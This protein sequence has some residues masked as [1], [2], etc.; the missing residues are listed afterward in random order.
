[1]N[2]SGMSQARMMR[3]SGR[4]PWYERLREHLIHGLDQHNPKFLAHF[5]RQIANV[6]FVQLGDDDGFDPRPQG[7]N[8]LLLQ[9]TDREDG[10]RR[11]TSP[12]MAT[13]LLTDRLLNNEASAVNMAIPAEGP[14]LGTAPAGT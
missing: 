9:S 5:V 10:P 1:M 12:V 3:R 4:R 2:S 13:S 7:S 8:R 6:F 14:S 11:V